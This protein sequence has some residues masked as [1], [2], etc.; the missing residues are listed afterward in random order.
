MTDNHEAALFRW[1]S[2]KDVSAIHALLEAA[3]RGEESLRGWTSEA[4]LLQGPRTSREE[5]MERAT[6]PRSGFLLAERV[7]ELIGCVY[8]KDEGGTA[9]LGMFAVRP[10]C[11]GAGIGRALLAESDRKAKAAWGV[12]AMRMTV[13]SLRE[14]LI[15]YYERRGYRR[16][17][18][19]EPFPFDDAAG[20]LTRDFH[21][22]V[23]VKPV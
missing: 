1:A 18:E 14:D 4:H 22:T 17:G 12:I 23:L 9:Y 21:L 2:R 13:I 10:A 15:A 11:Q 3:Y 6:G 5:V 7:G 16:T 8:L 20:A 19:T